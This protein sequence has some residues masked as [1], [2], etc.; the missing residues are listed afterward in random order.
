VSNSRLVKVLVALSSFVLHSLFILLVIYFVWPILGLYWN[1]KPAVGIDLFLSVD[2]LTY[3]R[4][5]F[6]WPWAWKYIWYGGTPLVQSY[7]LLH[8]Y[9]MLPLVAWFSAVQAVQVYVL[10]TYVLFFVFSYLLFYSFSKSR[11]L[12]AVL[13]IAT[14]YSYN[15]WSPLYWAG[16]I[17]YVATMFLLPL[18]LYL[19]VRMYETGNRKYIYLAGLLSGLFILGHPQSFIAYTVP[20][21][22][23]FILFFGSEKVKIFRWEKFA[24]LFFYGL[25]ILFVGF[26]Q[27]GIG[28]EVVGQ[29][30][31]LLGSAFSK[32]A[33]EIGQSYI[34]TQAKETAGSPIARTF[35]VY[36]R[37]NVLFFWALGLAFA[38]T[39]LS[40]FLA[41]VTR[42]K[43]SHHVKLLFPA[44]LIFAYLA[45]FL[46][47]FAIGINPLSGG[48]FRVFWPSMVI[49]GTITSVLW[50]IST[51][52]LE[53]IIGKWKDKP[54]IFR[55]YGWIFGTVLSLVV[56]VIGVPFLQSTYTGFQ[57]HMLAYVSESSAFPTAL[58]LNLKKGDWPE[59]LPKLVPDWMDPNDINYR[60][61]DMDAT[62]NIWWS[63]VFKMPLARGYLDGTPKGP[64]AENYA[65]WQYWQNITLLKNEAIERWGLTEEQASNQ[66]KFLLDWHSIRYVEGYPLTER[67]YAAPLSSYIAEDKNLFIR[68]EIILVFRPEKFFQIEGRGWNIPDHNQELKYYEVK[69]EAV[70]PIYNVTNAPAVLVVGDRIAQDVMMRDL[71]FLNLNSR[72]AIIIQWNKPIDSLPV[73]EIKNFDLIILYRYKYNKSVKAFGN[74]EKYVKGGGNLFIDTGTEQKESTSLK[75]PELF[76]F[77]QSERKPLGNNWD[78]KIEEDSIT[79]GINFENFSE[80]IFD[81]Q[82]WSFAYPA[83]GLRYGAKVLVS[84]HGKPVLASYNLGKGKV[85]WSGMNFAGHVQRFKNQEEINL[86]KNIL[87]Y[88]MDFS[89]DKNL[90]ASFERPTSEKAI[91]RGANAKGIL[92][93]EANYPSW[94]A[95]VKSNKGS[96]KVNIYRAGPMVYGYMYAFVPESMRGENFEAIF[97]Y[98]GEM[99]YKLA[100]FIS[101]LSII[102]VLDHLLAG[103]KLSRHVSHKGKHVLST[104]LGKW[105]GKEDEV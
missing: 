103:G 87:F 104:S 31:N 56:L 4:D 11:G 37:T 100:Y 90:E 99:V 44:V 95:T 65:G 42:R 78:F 35:D 63:S 92:F 91:I 52:N 80:P 79:Q 47:S 13:S 2:F 40:T 70:S 30:F 6:G 89:K 61:Y 38:V 77:E 16:S 74:L 45:L 27:A 72:K 39:I 24:T 25:V 14:A 84:N 97:E 67:P 101:F 50:R 5:H 34:A 102:F 12:A 18:S 88:F 7:P 86:F 19:V 22:A 33:Q 29:F 53:V 94:D 8:Y 83:S 75:L 85:V 1:Q 41:F 43:I 64:D 36:H 57:K 49:L 93:K 9:L 55:W 54:G 20:I 73:A 81:D 69:K 98:H 71:A 48:W 23:I 3:L 66:S 76:P 82:G 60:L 68:D 105:W 17:P 51:D 21:T 59:K 28:I 15:L 96:K 58:S 26:P 62:L 46:Y 32:G 10:S